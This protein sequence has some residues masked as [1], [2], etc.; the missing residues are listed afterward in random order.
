MEELIQKLKVAMADTVA[1]RL[2]TQQYHWNV[3]G[4]DF[5]E[6]HLLFQ[7]IYEEVYGAIDTFGEQIRTLDAYA[8]LSARRIVELTNIADT[9]V[10]LNP[11]EMVR[12]LY[13]DNNTV[14]N[15][16]FDTYKNA[17]KF[18]ELGLSNFLQDRL[19]AHKTHLYLLRSVLKSQG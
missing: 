3:E 9:E 8:P 7:R 2:K 12:V 5:Y 6:Y 10:A 15:T 19:T 13:T 11:L 17:E 16:L 4:P 18:N 14:L 1:F